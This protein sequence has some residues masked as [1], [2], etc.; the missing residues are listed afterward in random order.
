MFAPPWK[1]CGHTS[2]TMMPPLSIQNSIFAPPFGN[3][4]NETLP[5]S[6]LVG[7]SFLSFL[8]HP[9]DFMSWHGFNPQQIP[10]FFLSL[11]FFSSLLFSLF[12][13]SFFPSFFCPPPPL[14]PRLTFFFLLFFFPFLFF[15]FYFLF[16]FFFPFLLHSFPLFYSPDFFLLLSSSLFLIVFVL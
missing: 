10:L 6:I 12:C 2:L 3:F 13:T 16:P 9:L 7:S 15:L 5:G 14:S 1:S 4:L 11:F 8:S